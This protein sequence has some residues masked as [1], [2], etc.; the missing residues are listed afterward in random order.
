MHFTSKVFLFGLLA[1]TSAGPLA[2]RQAAVLQSETYSQ[3]QVSDGVAGSALD[4]VNAA[5]PI[6]DLDPAT[7]SEDDIQRLK[8]A[9]VIAEDA[10][11]GTGGFNEQ[12]DAAEAAGDDTTALQNG[13]IKNKVLKL[14]LQVLVLEIQAAQGN[15]N[16]A[17]LQ[18]Q[19]TK[20]NNNIQQ[21]EAAA[22]EASVG[23]GAQFSGAEESD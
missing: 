5:F 10:E 15:P 18:E 20:L 12:I 1:L 2:R 22:G 13:K 19:L 6:T 21:D 3:F 8:D 7:V 17:K 9:R 14:Q 11:V 4:E 16:D 23:V